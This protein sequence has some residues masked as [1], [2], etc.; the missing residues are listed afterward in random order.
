VL[1]AEVIGVSGSD[2]N[3]ARSGQYSGVIT[4]NS[5]GIAATAWSTHGCLLLFP[6][7]LSINR[8]V[9]STYDIS[10]G[11]QGL[12]AGMGQVGYDIVPN[13]VTAAIGGGFAA[14]PA[15]EDEPTVAEVNAR[16]TGH[17]FPLVTWGGYGGVLLDPAADIRAWSVYTAIDWVVF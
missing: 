4:G 13:R 8:Q 9:A 3:E 5:Y 7:P 10:G 1:R 2:G 14:H 11:G 16:I 17:P 12:V 6:D 15:A